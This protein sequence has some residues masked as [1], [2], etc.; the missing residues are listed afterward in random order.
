MATVGY[1]PS[2]Q[3]EQMAI[4]DDILY[5]LMNDYNNPKDIKNVK[6]PNKHIYE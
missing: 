1:K 3:E 6:Q 5:A 4:T 2:P